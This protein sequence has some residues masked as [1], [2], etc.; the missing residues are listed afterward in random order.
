MIPMKSPMNQRLMP[1]IFV[2]LIGAALIALILSALISWG[3]ALPALALLSIAGPAFPAFSL[4]AFLVLIV[5]GRQWAGQR[6]C[7]LLGAGAILSLAMLLSVARSDAPQWPPA[8]PSPHAIRIVEFNASSRNRVPERAVQW[9][10][11]QRP[12]MVVLLEAHGNGAEIAQLLAPALPHLVSCRGT[13]VC[14]TMIFSRLEPVERRGLAQGDAA[15]RKTVSAAY[16]RFAASDGNIGVIALHLSR[17]LPVG[18]QQRELAELTSRIANVP[19]DG[20]V[21]L[22]DFNAPPWSV[23]AREASRILGVRPVPIQPSWP[24]PMSALAL[25][26]FLAIDH[27]LL[28]PGWSA[29]SVDRGPVLGSD[30]YPF[31]ITLR[32]TV[33]QHGD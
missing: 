13:R 32:R 5:A 24:A 15:N 10:L 30:H 19:R 22:G 33:P 23:T 9:I 25:P 20:L 3:P 28:G 11:A 2:W 14:S 1:S 26:A 17:P 12:D 6:T 4:L 27:V 21:V 18:R 8:A 31:A 29:A 7:G 16:M